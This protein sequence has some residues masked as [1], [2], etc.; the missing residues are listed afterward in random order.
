MEDD[1][2]GDQRQKRISVDDSSKSKTEPRSRLFNLRFD[3]SEERNSLR[4]SNA[5]NSVGNLRS[6]STLPGGIILL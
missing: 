5:S 6:S 1:A 2:D 3:K 4:R